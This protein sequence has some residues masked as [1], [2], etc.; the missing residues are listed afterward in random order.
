MLPAYLAMDTA[1]SLLQ[2]KCGEHVTLDFL[3]QHAHEGNI[4]LFALVREPLYFIKRVVSPQLPPSN[5]APP[6]RGFQLISKPPRALISGLWPAGMNNVSR[7]QMEA[8]HRL[9]A[10]SK[11]PPPESPTTIAMKNISMVQCFAVVDYVLLEPVWAGRIFASRESPRAT[12]VDWMS[13]EGEMRSILNKE[14]ALLQYWADVGLSSLAKVTKGWN[15]EQRGWRL[16]EKDL[17]VKTG[18]LNQLITKCVPAPTSAEPKILEEDQ[19]RPATTQKQ[20]K[21]L[22]PLTTSKIKP[23]LW[24]SP[25]CNLR[26]AMEDGAL[27]LREARVTPGS[28]GKSATW[29][30]A[31]LALCLSKKAPNKTWKVPQDDLEAFLIDNF[32]EYIDE[33]YSKTPAPSIYD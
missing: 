12:Y 17:F 7:A 9:V 23:D 8:L 1:L 27:W 6:V 22:V 19:K 2:K 24:P 3:L 32:P 15:S 26:N 10:A 18:D 16:S 14:A 31:R 20:K 28:H 30:P 5:T 29:N 13:V 21:A 25:H 11:P 4:A 33:W